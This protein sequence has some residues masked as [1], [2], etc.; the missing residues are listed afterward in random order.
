MEAALAAQIEST[1]PEPTNA[2]AKHF[3]EFLVQ[4][5][6]ITRTQLHQGLTQQAEAK[7]S[8]RSTPLGEILVRCGYL[9]RFMLHH[10]LIEWHHQLIVRQEA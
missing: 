10:M 4:Q 5:S 2:E 7:R 6:H 3:G 8:D 9:E 1:A